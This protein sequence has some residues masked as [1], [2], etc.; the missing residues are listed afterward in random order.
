MYKEYFNT[1][2]P[3]QVRIGD[4]QY[5]LRRLTG[6]DEEV[7]HPSD[8]GATENYKYTVKSNRY[9]TA[10]ANIAK[11]NLS[12]RTDDEKYQTHELLSRVM[13]LGSSCFVGLIDTENLSTDNNRGLRAYAELT[14]TRRLFTGNFNLEY[15]DLF[16]VGKD[17]K[18][19][20]YI[21]LATYAIASL[22]STKDQSKAS[23]LI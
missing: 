9:T 20:A 22:K 13:N 8:E 19:S 23:D 6:W 17:T 1:L 4:K 10:I 7:S 14:K 15:Y 2:Q 12:P 5:C 16:D 11:H 3:R 21:Y 18:K